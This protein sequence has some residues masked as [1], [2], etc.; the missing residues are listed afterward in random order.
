LIPMALTSG[1]IENVDDQSLM[2]WLLTACSYLTNHQE[3]TV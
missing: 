3:P 1:L 2:Q